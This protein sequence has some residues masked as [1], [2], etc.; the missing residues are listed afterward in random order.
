MEQCCAFILCSLKYLCDKTFCESILIKKQKK[1][2]EIFFFIL[3]YIYV[4]IYVNK[5]LN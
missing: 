3:T 1:K 4:H 5:I 2:K